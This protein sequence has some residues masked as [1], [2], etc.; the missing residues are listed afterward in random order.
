[1][2]YRVN[3]IIKTEFRFN[4]RQMHTITCRGLE[5]IPDLAGQ[6]KTGASFPQTNKLAI[7]KMQAK[8]DGV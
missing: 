4:L 7:F 6:N 2:Q 8:S 3:T 1:M 5:V